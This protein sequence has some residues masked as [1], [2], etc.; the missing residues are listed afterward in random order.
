MPSQETLE[1]GETPW[2]SEDMRDVSR[3]AEGFQLLPNVGVVSPDTIAS[4]PA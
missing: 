1:L 4:G 3:L 2:L